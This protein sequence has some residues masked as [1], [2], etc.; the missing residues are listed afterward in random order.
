MN[1]PED[2]DSLLF[3]HPRADE[4]F[5]YLYSYVL[6]SES[7]DVNRFNQQQFGSVSAHIQAELDVWVASIDPQP[8][9]PNHPSFMFRFSRNYGDVQWHF[10][11]AGPKLYNIRF[12]SDRRG[13]QSIYAQIDVDSPT[14]A[15]FPRILQVALGSPDLDFVVSQQLE[16]K[17]VRVLSVKGTG[18][19]ALLLPR[20]R[21]GEHSVLPLH[22]LSISAKAFL[23]EQNNH[24]SMPMSAFFTNFK[25]VS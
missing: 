6:F 3:A 1:Y 21:D 13:S 12:D 4:I 22:E 11:P 17:Y 20:S 16:K 15:E 25:P 24:A 7:V 23:D 19:L 5:A 9:R 14:S 18:I 10:Q 2:K 8:L